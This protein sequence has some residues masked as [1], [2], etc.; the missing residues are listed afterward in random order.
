MD[1]ELT[2]RW[3]L[4]SG[5]PFRQTIGVY[6]SPEISNIGDDYVT[7]N[8]NDITFIYD[9]Q[10]NGRLPTYHRFDINLKKTFDSKKFKNMEWEIITGVT[11]MYSRQNIF[12]V[13]RV[14]NEK[15]YQL[16]IMPSLAV[17]LRF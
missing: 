10:N 11:N 8:A 7:G 12:Y 3:N 15:V 5:L 1:W 4:G 16:P 13:N 14:T 9:N 6:E 17:S 2:S